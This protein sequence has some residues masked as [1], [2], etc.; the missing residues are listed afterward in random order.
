MVDVYL[1][2]TAVDEPDGCAG[3]WV[4]GTGGLSY[5]LWA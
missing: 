3:V 4:W 5:A 1:A 2:G